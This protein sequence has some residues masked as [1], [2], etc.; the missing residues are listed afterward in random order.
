MKCLHRMFDYC[1]ILDWIK[2][3]DK[4]ILK[5]RTIGDKV[6]KLRIYYKEL[7]PVHWKFTTLEIIDY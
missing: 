7:F 1:L 5:E 3:P 6:R 4:I 2:K